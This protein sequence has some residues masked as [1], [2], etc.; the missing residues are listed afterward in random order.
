[1][2]STED[3]EEERRLAYVG[4]TRAKKNLYLSHAQMRML[5]GT[6]SRNIPSRFIVE[7]PDALTEKTG[8]TQR[9]PVTRWARLLE[10]K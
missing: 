8:R 4:I 1:M 2:Y 9:M 10:I 5:F 7:I 3:I 6:A